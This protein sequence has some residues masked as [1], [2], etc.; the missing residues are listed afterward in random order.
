MIR[1]S[2]TASANCCGDVYKRQEIDRDHHH[3]APHRSRGKPRNAK[4][5]LFETAIEVTEELMDRTLPP[6]VAVAGRVRLE[7]QRAHRRRQRQRHDQRNDRGAGDGQ[8]ELPVE[9]PGYAGDEH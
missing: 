2:D 1:V 7:Q 6:G 4:G 5:D 8:R 9:L 3:D